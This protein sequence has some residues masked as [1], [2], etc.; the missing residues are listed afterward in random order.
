MIHISIPIY[1]HYYYIHT[2]TLQDCMCYSSRPAWVET[3]QAQL[4]PIPGP[5][6]WFYSCVQCKRDDRRSRDSFNGRPPPSG[7]VGRARFAIPLQTIFRSGHLWSRRISTS[8]AP[9]HCLSAISPSLHRRRG[10]T[11]AGKSPNPPSSKKN[12]GEGKRTE[13]KMLG[14]LTPSSFCQVIINRFCFIF[15][16]AV[17]F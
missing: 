3:Y 7:T 17:N 11:M 4:D 12:K 8:R 15:F 9:R 13:S 1:I 14:A 10:P 6:D 5:C 16:S 2:I